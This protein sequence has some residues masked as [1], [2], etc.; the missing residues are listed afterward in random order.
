MRRSGPILSLQ[1]QLEQAQRHL[2]QV[3][4]RLDEQILFV[5][6]LAANGQAT[7]A[8]ERLLA[9]LI[10]RIGTSTLRRDRLEQIVSHAL[11]RRKATG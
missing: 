10:E 5:E 7:D 11:N 1:A 8:A 2:E 3:E 4:K 9:I 6:R